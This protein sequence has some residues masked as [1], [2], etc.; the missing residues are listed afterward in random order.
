MRSYFVAA[1]LYLLTLNAFAGWFGFGGT[2]WQE[3]VLLHDGNKLVVERS[4]TR[5]GPHEIG[6]QGSYTKETLTFRHPATTKMITWEDNATPDLRASGFLPMALDVYPDGVY[7]VLSPMGCLSYN[8]WGR[9]NPPYVVF[10][11]VDKT[12]NRVDL[13]ELPAETKA[14]N[15]ISSSPDTEVERI[16]K[17]FIDS[18]TI[19]R[20]T[21]EYR[22][23]E[24][25]TILRTAMEAPAGRWGEMVHDG[26]GGWI[27][28]GWFKKQPNREACF[29]YCKREGVPE[30]NCPC[31]RLFKEE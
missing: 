29:Q 23:P 8:K 24:N 21:N 30:E 28:I 27:G 12:W 3:E 26:K 5:G 16:G 20:I 2:T 1:A 10:R 4:V 19:K 14:P 9:P 11:F 17:R 25:K 31:K 15:M 7:L 22:Q 6:Q 18:E 13:S